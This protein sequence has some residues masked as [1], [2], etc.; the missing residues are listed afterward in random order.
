M[1]KIIKAEK[2]YGE[3]WFLYIGEYIFV[4]NENTGASE[5]KFLCIKCDDKGNHETDEVTHISPCVIT[6]YRDIEEYEVKCTDDHKIGFD[7]S[8]KIINPKLNNGNI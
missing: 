7:P 6:H 3:Q 2:Q 8:I 5:T 1:A 4:Y